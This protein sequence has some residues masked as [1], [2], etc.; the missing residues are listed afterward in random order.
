MVIIPVTGGDDLTQTAEATM[1]A[2]SNPV[3]TPPGMTLAVETTRQAT[4]NPRATRPAP[5]ETGTPAIQVVVIG[6]SAGGQ[7]LR[8][9]QMGS[10]P[11]N[12][13][14]LGGLHS[15]FAPS[16]VRV[17]EDIQAYF[18]AHPEEIPAGITLH[19][20]SNANPDAPDLPNDAR[21]RLNANSTDLNLN[22]DCN[23]LPSIAFRS[24]DLTAGRA[25]FSEPETQAIR[26][27]ALQTL[28]VAVIA[29]EAKSPGWVIAGACKGPSLF[30]DALAQNYA[31]ASGYDVNKPDSYFHGDATDWLDSRGIPA[32]SILLKDY[33]TPDSDIHIRAI[34]ALFARAAAG[35]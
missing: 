11:R 18:T 12:V 24:Q 19:L 25:P 29:Y 9:V 1:Q 26:D 7:E 17:V 33:T 14:V 16:S 10:G 28:P 21:G 3:T 30:S 15:G 23:W 2:T 35:K 8:V 27:Y 5:T 32:I 31:Y 34:K 20:L 13:L 22:W 6:R 4:P